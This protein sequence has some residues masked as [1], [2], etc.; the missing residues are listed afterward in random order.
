M[1]ESAESLKALTE[2]WMEAGWQRGDTDTLLALH[3]PNFVDHAAPS[4]REMTREGFAEGVRDLY[5]AFPD[6]YATVDDLVIDVAAA[7]VAVRWSARGTQRGAFMGYTASGRRIAFRGIEIIRI[8]AGL[9]VERW[10]EWDGL[11]LR[12]QLAGE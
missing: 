6:F 5:R 2:R 4:G 10:G 11:D 3:A 9:I 1:P 8:V 7:R 12:S